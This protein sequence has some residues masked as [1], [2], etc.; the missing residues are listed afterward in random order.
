M[1]KIFLPTL[2][3]DFSTFSLK[4]GQGQVEWAEIQSIKMEII[5]EG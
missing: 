3:P 1:L 4:F 5:S 2:F